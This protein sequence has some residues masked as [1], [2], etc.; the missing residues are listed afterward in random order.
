MIS[1]IPV[2]DRHAALELLSLQ[3]QAYLVE[4]ERIG[5]PDLPPLADT[6]DALQSSEE[7]F[8]GVRMDGEL[9][10]AIAYTREE[11]LVTI[12][13]LMVS[14]RFFRRGIGRALLRFV[15][16]KETGAAAFLVSTATANEPAVRLYEQAGYRKA[17]ERP[18]APGISLTYFRKEIRLT[19]QN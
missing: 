1:P 5:F 2:E 9:A 15:E 10:G 13:R 8:F 4:A 18:I 3:M 12:C 11:R 17:E 14:P 6:L 16:E 19:G 7:Q